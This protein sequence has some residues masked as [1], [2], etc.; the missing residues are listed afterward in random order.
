[1]STSAAVLSSLHRLH[2]QGEAF[3]CLTLAQVHGDIPLKVGA[4]MLVTAT[5]AIQGSLG[6]GS[7]EDAALIYSRQ[8]LEQ[9]RTRSCQVITWKLRDDLKLDQDGEVTLVFEHEPSHVW[10]III[11]GAGHISQALVRLLASLNCDVTIF[12][13]RPEML[14]RLTQAP[15]IHPRKVDV[16]AEAVRDLPEGA[17][18]ALMTQGHRTDQPVLEAILKTRT[19]PYLG[20]IGSASKA[21]VLR[22]E[23]REAGLPG[24]LKAAFRCPMG[25]P[26][27]N[28][29]PEEIALSIAAE[30]LQ[31]RDQVPR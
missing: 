8:I 25:L 30:M 15:H 19:F 31:V 1:M 20:V 9:S 29:T 17:F 21:A 6:A 18:V 10:P 23:L 13:T 16:L 12:D 24:D 5:G 22:R 4:K 7:V 28:D 27:G 14:A 26:L 11:F 2:A 3:V